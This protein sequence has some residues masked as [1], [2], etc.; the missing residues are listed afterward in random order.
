MN[1]L[2][3]FK[4]IIDVYVQYYRAL[5][6]V[7]FINRLNSLFNIKKNIIIYFQCLIFLFFSKP[8]SRC[9]FKCLLK[10]KGIFLKVVLLANAGS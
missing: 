3:S 8:S 6:L 5:L 4:T 7:A 2:I 9:K 1:W 10:V